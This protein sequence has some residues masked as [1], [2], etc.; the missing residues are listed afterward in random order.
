[1]YRADVQPFLNGLC[2]QEYIIRKEKL[3]EEDTACIIYDVLQG[4]AKLHGQGYVHRDFYPGNIIQNFRDGETI[5]AVIDF[6]EMQKQSEDTRPCFRFSGYHAPEIVLHDESYDEK[7]EM[8]SLGVIMW[9]LLFGSCPFGG[10]D[11]FGRVIA[12]SWA[13]YEKNAEDC[14]A[15]VREGIKR[16]KKSLEEIDGVSG[17]CAELLQ[18]LL[19]EKKEA[20]ITSSVALQHNFF[21]MHRKKQIGEA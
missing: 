18:L 16:L 5:S 8:F 9:E 14:H 2:I 12:E 1:M 21:K 3:S 19:A 10:Y 6:D 17:E 4:L 15:E 20:R 7:S 13:K 11:Y